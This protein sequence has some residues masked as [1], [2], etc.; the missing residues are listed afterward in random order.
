M[1]FEIELRKRHLA[2]FAGSIAA[3]VA[4][5]AL[6]Q[7]LGDV[8]A[9]GIDGLSHASPGWLW[10]AA[11]CFA[12]T[13]G[14]SACAWRFALTRCGGETSR[15]SRTP[16]AKVAARAASGCALKLGR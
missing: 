4:V 13:L 6:P 9:D 14:A 3:L 2:L 10:L 16:T 15:A 7:L 5:A 12:C 11:L 8:V 1:P